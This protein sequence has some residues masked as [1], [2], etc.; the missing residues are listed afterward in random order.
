MSR[1]IKIYTNPKDTSYLGLLGTSQHHDEMQAA[2]VRTAPFVVPA[3]SALVEQVPTPPLAGLDMTA[4]ATP[5]T[6]AQ[7]RA[8]AQINATSERL[9]YRPAVAALPS[10]TGG[11]II[12]LVK[13]TREHVYVRKEVSHEQSLYRPGWDR[14]RH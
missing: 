1:S 10:S 13:D 14:D 7:Q 8:L 3:F 12:D 5:M 6:M 2:R 4:P 11:I 9:G